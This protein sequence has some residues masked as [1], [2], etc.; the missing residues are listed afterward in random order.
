MFFVCPDGSGDFETIRD[1]VED[2]GVSHGDTLELCC[3]QDFTGALNRNIEFHAKRLVIRSECDDP[4]R[5]EIDCQGKQV[6]PS[7]PEAR[8]GFVFE[9]HDPV[10]VRGVTI[11]EGLAWS[12]G[13]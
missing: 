1:A 8:R 11:Y 6:I 7:L 10:T 4:E 9:S 13:T 5:C 2:A 3:D 12:A